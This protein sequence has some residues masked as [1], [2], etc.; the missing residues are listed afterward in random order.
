MGINLGCSRFSKISVLFFCLYFS[1]RASAGSRLPFGMQYRALQKVYKN[2]V[3]VFKS[4]LHGLGLFC[5]KEI[6]AGQM[7]IEYSG[8]L[9]RKSLSDP[10]ERYYESRVGQVGG[11]GGFRVLQRSSQRSR[12]QVVLMITTE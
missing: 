9:I 7:V 3:G 4:N 12:R 6:D 5:T 8:H 2:Y 10:R 1:F 11:E